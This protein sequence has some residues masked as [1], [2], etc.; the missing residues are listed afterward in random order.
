MAP[1]GRDF[2]VITDGSEGEVATDDFGHAWIGGIRA[3]QRCDQ[4]T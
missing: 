4:G 1:G 3:L 2:M